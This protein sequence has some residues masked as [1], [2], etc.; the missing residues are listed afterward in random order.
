MLCLLSHRVMYCLA[1][2]ISHCVLDAHLLF[3]MCTSFFKMF[4][5]ID[6]C[7]ILPSIVCVGVETNSTLGIMKRLIRLFEPRKLS[8]F[9][10]AYTTSEEH[11]ILI[12]DCYIGGSYMSLGMRLYF[13]CI[14]LLMS[15][16]PMFCSIKVHI[17]IHD[18][19][20]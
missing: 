8:P 7:V 14:S 13:I 20:L 10:D 12:H 6:V 1:L 4:H 15:F 5:Y 2:R 11:E 19:S 17:V 16:I 18:V 9:S 3:I